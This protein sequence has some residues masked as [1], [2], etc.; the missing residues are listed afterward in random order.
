M[1]RGRYRKIRCLIKP[2][3]EELWC[4]YCFEHG[5]LGTVTL[6]PGNP[7]E[8]LVYFIEDSTI[9]G[10]TLCNLFNQEIGKLADAVVLLEEEL[11]R[12][13]TGI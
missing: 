7:R 1:K 3:W 11:I 4:W 13:R 12:R 9:A 10:G 8:E 5:A 6:Q 2:S